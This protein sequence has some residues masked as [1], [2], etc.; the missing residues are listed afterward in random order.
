MKKLL[1]ICLLFTIQILA[2]DPIE[3][4]IMTGNLESLENLLQVKESLSHQEKIKYLDLAQEMIVQK[5]NEVNAD[6]LDPSPHSLQLLLGICG[7]IIA[8]VVTAKYFCEEGYNYTNDG[9]YP[10]LIPAIIHLGLIYC[11]RKGHEIQIKY[12]KD[13]DLQMK[14]TLRIKQAIYDK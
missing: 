10:L 4:A 6:L 14:N 8:P 1:F 13:Q 2:Q 5:R 7:I 3:K 11:L 9:I 12:F